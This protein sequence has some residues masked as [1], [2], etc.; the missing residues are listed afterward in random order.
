MNRTTLLIVGLLLLIVADVVLAFASTFTAL[1]IGLVLWGL[2]MGFTQGLLS[3][4]IADAAPASL[5]GTAFGVYNLITGVV[6]LAASALAGLLWD[7]HG[8]QATFLA[9]ALFAA[10]TV[11]GLLVVRDRGA[12]ASASA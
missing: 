6:L 5:R 8:P 7:R 10:L 11:V 3:T 12:D 4:L 9:G 2:Y 1:G